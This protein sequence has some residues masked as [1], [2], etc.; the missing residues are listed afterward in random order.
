MDDLGGAL[1]AVEAG[2]PRPHADDR[3]ELSGWIGIDG[4]MFV[5]FEKRFVPSGRK[6]FT[7]CSNGYGLFGRALISTGWYS[8]L[9]TTFV[10][11]N[12]WVLSVPQHSL[13]LHKQI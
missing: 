7:F 8:R 9:Y 5:N 12:T 1:V 4:A 10:D 13:F 2:H 11:N 6:C 3:L